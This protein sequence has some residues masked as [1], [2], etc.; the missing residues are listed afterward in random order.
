MKSYFGP[1]MR[2]SRP[3]FGPISVI[4]GGLLGG[5]LLAVILAV[6]EAFVL[7]RA[8]RP[9]W[10]LTSLQVLAAYA[11]FGWVVGLLVGVTWSGRRMVRRSALRA[12][13]VPAATV[14]WLLSML[15][16]VRHDTLPELRAHAP[17]MLVRALL[18]FL[19]CCLVSVWALRRAHGRSS[20]PRGRW[21]P[22][23]GGA[24]ATLGV[25]VFAVCAQ[26]SA[27]HIPNRSAADNAP[28]IVMVVVDALRA[29]RLGAY[30]YSR[31]TSPAMDRM[32]AEGA[33]F[34]RTYSH[35]NR[36]IVSIPS[37]FTSLYPSE[38]GAVGRG[39]VIQPLPSSRTTIAELLQGRG[40]ATVGLMSNVYLKRA[41]GLTQGFD[42]VDEF[43]TA[44]RRLS[45]FRVLEAAGLMNTPRHK[46]GASPYAPEVT[47]RAREWMQ[48][49]EDR[50]YFLYVHYMDV[51]HPYESDPQ[52]VRRLAEGISA[53][54]ADRLFD[55]TTQ[56]VD[57]PR[58][59][60][61]PDS[62]LLE[63]SNLYDACIATVDAHVGHMLDAI[64]TGGAKR[65]TVVVLTADHGD[66]FLEHGS[67]YHTN[68]VVEELIRVPLLVWRSD[69]AWPPARIE[70][71]A[72][73]VDVL[74]TLAD[75]TG[76]TAPGGIEGTSLLDC[77][78]RGTRAPD[79]LSI[80]E[81]DYCAAIVTPSWKM[82]FV[83]TT[84]VYSLYNLVE[85][86]AGMKDIASQ[87]TVVRDTL[88]AR[89]DRYMV[90][91]AARARQGHP[92]PA[93]EETIRQLRALGY[94]Q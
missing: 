1:D 86:P 90:G 80:S 85:D 43:G 51:H 39:D 69:H 19:P 52:E 40:Y 31:A 83:D 11:G 48:R 42:R 71:M 75:I 59:I 62:L 16:M 92:E 44:H 82:M 94:L 81:G 6:V 68:V 21:V 57:G 45:V 55:L 24:A 47:A 25:I 5:S 15:F 74:P 8:T 18:A 10:G 27:H 35:G 23:F 54:E 41:F 13:V 12:I 78:Q 53:A 66:E 89:L 29:D 28:N 73:H 67:L 76:A 20:R 79:S 26:S 64:R 87:H 84:G 32:A 91:A 70:G 14:A 38:H 2:S 88:R 61:L 60:S 56:L 3:A 37:L 50:P 58:P 34:T 4:A 33:V 30:G 9:G 46:V 49:L 77:L 36:T 72:R 93:N 65:P 22:G 17:A 63:L 7:E